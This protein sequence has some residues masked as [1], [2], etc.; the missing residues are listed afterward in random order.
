MQNLPAKLEQLLLSGDSPIV[1]PKTA[2][3]LKAFAEQPEPEGPTQDQV[4]I[5][6][7]KLAMAMAQSKVSDAEAAARLEMY[8]L[9]LCDVPADDLRAAFVDLVKTCKFLPTPAEVRTAALRKGAIRKY[10][11]S[12]A[13]HLVWKHNTEW[14][15]EGARVDP[16]ALQALL[17]RPLTSA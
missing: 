8:W 9:A 13:G 2:G 17:A 7:G 12:R 15:E 4:G 1:G 10:A 16:S 14:K 5:M 11:K 6:I 3:H